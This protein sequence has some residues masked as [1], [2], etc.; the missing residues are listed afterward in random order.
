MSFTPSSLVSPRSHPP[1]F[2]ASSQHL[3]YAL[4]SSADVPT[5]LPYFA[6]LRR[7][8]KSEAFLLHLS[9]AFAAFE[10]SESDS[11]LQIITSMR[12]P[13]LA[14]LGTITRLVLALSLTKPKARRKFTIMF[15]L[16]KPYRSK[17]LSNLQQ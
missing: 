14:I 12:T 16:P 1:V 5:F 6:L 11:V 3:V 7:P 13:S 9:L 15:Y 10:V 17:I 4:S 2:V 8:M